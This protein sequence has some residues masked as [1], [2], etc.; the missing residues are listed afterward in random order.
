MCSSFHDVSSLEYEDII[1]LAYCLESMGDDDDCTI[2][3]ELIESYGDR[4]F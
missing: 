3:E 4:L 2:S 1:C